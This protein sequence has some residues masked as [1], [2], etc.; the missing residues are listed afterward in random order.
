MRLV[1]S[2]TRY[3][4]AALVL[5]VGFS[6]PQHAQAQDALDPLFERLQAVGPDDYKP[7][8]EKIWAEWSKSGS[9]AMDLLLERGTDAMEAGETGEAINHFTALT[10]HAP[11]FAQGYHARATAYYQA[12]LYGPALED[13]RRTLALEPRH[14]AALS[15]LAVM[16][17]EW[18]D[19]KGALQVYREVQAIHPH[20]ENL[21]TKIDELEKQTAGRAL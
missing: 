2:L 1:T 20:R 5:T 15:G 3:A 14:F 7:I 11:N 10:D 19:L 16:L 4:V 17:E 12:G 18:G 8:E 9:P 6:L 21:S 13:I